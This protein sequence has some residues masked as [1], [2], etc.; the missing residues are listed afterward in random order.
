MS[1]KINKIKHHPAVM[2]VWCEY[3]SDTYGVSLKTG[4]HHYGENSITTY[5]PENILEVLKEVDSDKFHL[6]VKLINWL[7]ENRKN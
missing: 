7:R 6:K 1:N 5:S 2:G 4:Y 3:Q